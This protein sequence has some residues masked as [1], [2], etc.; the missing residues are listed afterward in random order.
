VSIYAASKERSLEDVRESLATLVQN[1]EADARRNRILIRELLDNDRDFFYSSSIEILKTSPGSRGVQYLVA[2]LVANGLLLQAICD[3]GL[4]REQA[5]T[6]GRAAVRTDPA[7]DAGLARGLAD[8][9]TGQGTVTVRDAPRLMEVLCEIGDPARMMSSML[10]L[11]RHPNAYL[12]SKAVKIVG[13]G[14]KSPKWVRQRLSDPDPRIRANAVE[15][16]WSVDSAEARSLLHFA[17]ADGHNRVVANALLG[18]YYLGDCT[19]LTELAKF[20]GDESAVT[21]ASAAWAMGETGDIRFQEI[22][23]RMLSDSDPIAR[24]RALS[25]LSRLKTNAAQSFNDATWHLAAR[26][27]TDGKGGRRALLA[28]AGNDNRDLPPIPSLNFHLSEHG[29]YVFSYKVSERPAPD[30]MSVVFLMPRSQEAGG[31]FRGAIES[32]LKWK[33]PND[34]WCIQPYLE[35]GERT[36][37]DA[38]RDPEGLTFTLSR[39]T[40]RKALNETVGRVTCDDLWSSI[41]RATTMEGGAARGTRH[42]FILSSTEEGR[43]AGHSVVVRS[44][45]GRLQMKAIATGTN[46]QVLAFCDAVGAPFQRVEEADVPET[47]RQAYLALLARYEILYQPVVDAAKSLKVRVQTAGGTGEVTVPYRE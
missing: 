12:R 45:S 11:L 43:L 33:R 44:R 13:R 30:A 15:A 14:S 32:C 41:W 5:F 47:V 9:E 34:L 17:L 23:R 21:R 26:T 10:R 8:S 40:L 35:T 28:I 18:L 16:L 39:D 20:A 46:P 3:P 19:A 27:M 31:A 24:K 42:I 6:L 29:S 25:A 4:S 2:L 1:F 38:G 22:L 7:A 37:P 36:M